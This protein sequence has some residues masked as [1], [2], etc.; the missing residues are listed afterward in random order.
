VWLWVQV[1][2]GC[3]FRVEGSELRAGSVGVGV[4]VLIGVGVGVGV[5]ARCGCEVCAWGVGVRVWVSVCVGVS[6]GVGVG[7]CVG[8]KCESGYG[9]GVGVGVGVAVAAGVVQVCVGV[10]RR[11]EKTR[12]VALSLSLC[13]VGSY[14]R[15]LCSGCGVKAL[16]AVVRIANIENHK[17][18]QRILLLVSFDMVKRPVLP[19]A[20][21]IAS[22]VWPIRRPPELKPG[23]YTL[24]SVNPFKLEGIW[25]DCRVYKADGSEVTLRAKPAHDE[26]SGRRASQC[27]QYGYVKIGKKQY[28]LHRLVA[29]NICNPSGRPWGPKLHAEHMRSDSEGRARWEDS[30][31]ANLRVS[32]ARANCRRQ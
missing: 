3:G 28:P 15:S 16:L 12:R 21:P 8:C 20:V 25:Y 29:F 6:V 18:V 14:G 23:L 9:F 30:R 27:R 22:Q 32:T 31:R 24:Q 5:D 1:G 13:S 10:Q 4:N 26:E 19:I 17:P 2:F 7:V 11:G